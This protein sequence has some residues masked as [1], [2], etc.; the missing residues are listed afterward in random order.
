M[1]A[2]QERDGKQTL[3]TETERERNRESAGDEEE[4]LGPPSLSQ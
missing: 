1:G 4:K 2:S 3:L